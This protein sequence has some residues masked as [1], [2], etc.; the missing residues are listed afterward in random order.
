MKTN[1]RFNFRKEL[2]ILTFFAFLYMPF[3]IFYQI[4]INNNGFC[5]QTNGQ[6]SEQEMRLNAIKGIILN[7]VKRAARR[8]DKFSLRDSKVLVINKNV[9]NL[10]LI[11]MIESSSVAMFLRDIE[12]NHNPVYVSNEYE[13]NSIKHELFEKE[14]SIISYNERDQEM[15]VYPGSEIF[16]AKSEF[17]NERPEF[18]FSIFDKFHGYGN[19]FY[20][21]TNYHIDLACCDGRQNIDEYRSSEH[22]KKN[23]VEIII[24]RKK[25]PSSFLILS[26]CGDLME[27]EDS[28]G[29]YRSDFWF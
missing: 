2:L 12:I 11:E 22:H 20:K 25:S 24:N 7:E 4:K 18:K 9:S 10:E 29:N 13:I 6:I 23:I 5:G 28:D 14:F 1:F 17:K 19:I 21:Y 27:K 26:N 16:S 15:F 8:E 3:L